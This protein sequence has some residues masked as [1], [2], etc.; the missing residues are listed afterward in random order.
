MVVVTIVDKI[1]SLSLYDSREVRLLCRYWTGD[2]PNDEANASNE[3]VCQVCATA[4]TLKSGDESWA[5]ENAGVQNA[6]RSKKQGAD[7]KGGKCRSRLAVWIAEP[8]LYI[9]T[10][11]N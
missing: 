9:D 8:I 2:R 11:L 5:T 3:N 10:A 1:T 6:I 7:R 4:V